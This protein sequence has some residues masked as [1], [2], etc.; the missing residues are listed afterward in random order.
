MSCKILLKTGGG[1]WRECFMP[2]DCPQA[3]HTL[4]G[5]W[6]LIYTAPKLLR[7]RGGSCETLSQS[8]GKRCPF[9]SSGSRVVL[10]L[11]YH[12]SPVTPRKPWAVV[13]LHCTVSVIRV[14]IHVNLC[15]NYCVQQYFLVYCF[16]SYVNCPFLFS[17]WVFFFPSFFF[18]FFLLVICLSSFK[19]KNKNKLMCCRPI[20]NL[21]LSLIL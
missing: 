10:S 20:C 15:E 4:D 16:F 8:Q 2:F 6:K 9:P 21:F 1:K 7:G 14:L 17:F 12:L 18:F 19:R 3:H 13:F 5:K 11:Q